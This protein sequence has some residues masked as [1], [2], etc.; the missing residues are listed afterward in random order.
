MAPEALEAADLAEIS[1]S[2]SRGVAGSPPPHAPPAS[3]APPA[4]GAAASGR[5][6]AE[7]AAAAGDGV[8]EG[9]LL[10]LPALLPVRLPRSGLGV[11]SAAGA[12]VEAPAGAGGA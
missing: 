4:S 12:G 3:S 8:S 9:I 7:A 1:G 10:A 5:A 6:G 2:R 11:A